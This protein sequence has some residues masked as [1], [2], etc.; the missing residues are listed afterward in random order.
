MPPLTTNRPER[1]RKAGK[2]T[3]DMERQPTGA[4]DLLPQRVVFI[5][6]E[7]G[8]AGVIGNLP[9]CDRQ[10]THAD[11][12]QLQLHQ[13]A[14]ALD[15]A[16]LGLGWETCAQTIGWHVGMHG[17]DKTSVLPQGRICDRR[18]PHAIADVLKFDLDSV[19]LQHRR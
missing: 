1:H 14:D 9:R 2:V 4:F 8:M 3:G 10:L 15:G 6:F 19:L 16:E 5:D 13:I 18:H 7:I 17:Q 11:A 12:W